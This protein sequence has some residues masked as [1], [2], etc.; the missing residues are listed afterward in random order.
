[1]QFMMQI[2]L[3]SIIS[4]FMACP[5]QVGSDVACQRHTPSSRAAVIGLSNNDVILFRPLI[6]SLTSVAL[7]LLSRCVRCVRCVEWKPR[8]NNW[9]RSRVAVSCVVRPTVSGLNK[10]AINRYAADYGVSASGS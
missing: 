7:R 3:I 2:K 4:N 1:M 6:T 8:L 5:P 9:V 10:C